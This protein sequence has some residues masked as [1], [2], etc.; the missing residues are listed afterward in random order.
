MT[1][2]RHHAGLIALGTIILLG[3]VLCLSWRLEDIDT[4]AAVTRVCRY[5]QVAM[6][7][8]RHHLG[9]LLFPERLDRRESPPVV[10]PFVFCIYN[11]IAIL[12]G[13]IYFRQVSQLAGFHAGPRAIR[14]A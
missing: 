14:P 9:E 8:T 4:H 5:P 2:T 6:T 11:I 10:Y 7:G 3:G 1:G 12:D 13:L